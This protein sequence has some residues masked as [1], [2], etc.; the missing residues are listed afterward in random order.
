MENRNFGEG[1]K[2]LIKRNL[3]DIITV[4]LVE[5]SDFKQSTS[6]KLKSISVLFN[7]IRGAGDLI[8]TF[9]EK[10]LTSLYQYSNDEEL[11]QMCAETAQMIGLHVDQNIVIPTVARHLNEMDKSALQPLANK[12]FILSNILSKIANISEDSVAQVLK[13]LYY[14]DIFNLPDSSYMKNILKCTFRI[15]EGLVMNLQKSCTKF[16][17]ELFLPLLFLGSLNETK[18]IHGEVGGVMQQLAVFCGFETVVDLYS[19]E[20]M[21]ILDKFNVTHKQWRRNSPDRFAFDTY[22]RNGGIALEKHWQ[23]VLLIISNCCEADRDIEMRMDMLALIDSIIEDKQLNEYIA[24]YIEFILKEI[25]LPATAWRTQ[26][27]N[28]SVRKAALTCIIKLYKYTIIDEESSLKFIKDIFKVLKSTMEDDW[29]PQLR[30]LSV[31]LIK[32]ILLHTKDKISQDDMIDLYPNLLKRLD[33]S[34]DSIRILMCQVLKIFFEIIKRTGFSESAYE[35]IINT[36]FIHLDDPKIE[37][38]LAVLDFLK[39]A[40]GMH[41]E[42]FLKVANKSLTTFSHTELCTALIDHCQIS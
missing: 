24:M 29:D 35:Y 25:L 36:A 4:I 8:S 7:I 22:V 20:L 5:I 3:K 16:H 32:Y 42:T 15:Y 23:D 1:S 39:E 27:P 18:D 14:L 10:I 2:Y 41:K 37:V 31:I 6:L 11:S 17:S 12:L 38:R 33:D 19:L 21:F 26:R 34:Q 28:Y 40:S 13:V 9:V 30:D